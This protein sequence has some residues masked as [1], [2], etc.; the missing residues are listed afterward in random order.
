MSGLHHRYSFAEIEVA[1][2]FLLS[3]NFRMDSPFLE[4]VSYLSRQE[5]A[6]VRS[7]EVARQSKSHFK[8][9]FIRD[10]DVE[11]LAFVSR[12]REDIQQWASVENVSA[13]RQMTRIV[14]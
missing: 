3:V 12:V 2:E 1:V 6:E 11:S 13:M 5:E 4:G 14:Y 8:D 10:D 7:N 9:I